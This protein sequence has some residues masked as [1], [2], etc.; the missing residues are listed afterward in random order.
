VDTTAKRG[1]ALLFLPMLGTLGSLIDGGTSVAKTVNDS[2]AMHISSKSC[3]VSRWNRVADYISLR[4]NTGVDCISARTWTECSCKEKKKRR[5]KDDKNAVWRNY[6]WMNNWAIKRARE[7]VC[8]YYT[9]YLEAFSCVTCYRRAT[10]TEM[11]TY[12]ESERRG[13]VLTG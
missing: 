8:A 12:R 13:L 5:Q 7:S 3:N 4:T 9:S 11:K 10:H 6:Q 1:D 2:K